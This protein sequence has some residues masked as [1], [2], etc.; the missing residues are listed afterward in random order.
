MS[1][2]NQFCQIAGQFWEEENNQFN[3]LDTYFA[4]DTVQGVALTY[5]QTEDSLW[6]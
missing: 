6:P 5:E 2:F 4:P 3:K 1:K